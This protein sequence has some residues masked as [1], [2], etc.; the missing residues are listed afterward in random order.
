M[1]R[2]LWMLMSTVQRVRCLTMNLKRTVLHN[3]LYVPIIDI[4]MPYFYII[5]EKNTFQNSNNICNLTTSVWV[6]C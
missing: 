6:I 2:S 1:I 3:I 5:V 4:Q